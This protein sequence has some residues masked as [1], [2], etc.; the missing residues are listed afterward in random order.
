MAEQLRTV[1]RVC[2]DDFKDFVVRV[3]SAVFESQ[4]E[5]QMADVEAKLKAER[6]AAKT[7]EETRKQVAA[8]AK[9][10]AEEEAA[11]NPQVV[12]DFSIVCADHLLGFCE[13]CRA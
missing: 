7:A 13:S 8:E 6:E 5:K 2:G 4:T 3:F 12:I 9:R 10:K 1:T 11:K